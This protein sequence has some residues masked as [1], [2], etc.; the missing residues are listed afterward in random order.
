MSGRLLAV[1][2]PWDEDASFYIFAKDSE[3]RDH[4]KEYMSLQNINVSIS[5]KVT[6]KINGRFENMN[7][8]DFLEKMAKAYDLVWFYDGNIVYIY[9]TDELQTQLIHVRHVKPQEVID[10]AKVLGVGSPQ[11]TIRSVSEEGI[12]LIS[13]PP[14]FVHLVSNLATKLDHSAGTKYADKETIK[15][16]TLEHAWAYDLDFSYR[17]SSITV[18]GVAT[19]LQNIMNGTTGITGS[20]FGGGRFRTAG[21]MATQVDAKTTAMKGLTGQGV[22]GNLRD[23]VEQQMPGNQSKTTQNNSTES[24]MRA[25]SLAGSPPAVIM[26]DMRR[27]AVIVKD[28]KEQ[29]PLYEELIKE[30]D[31]PVKVIAIST[32]IMEIDVNYARTLG[33]QYFNVT[34]GGYFAFSASPSIPSSGSI[35]DVAGT[36]ANLL[37]QGHAKC[38]ESVTSSLIAL[39]T[40]GAGR[41]LSRPTVLTFDNTEAFIQDQTTFYVRVSGTYDANLY[42]ISS[43]L[44]MRVTPHLIKKGDEEKIQLFIDLYDGSTSSSQQE[45]IDG[46]PTTEEIRLTTQAVINKGESLLIGG[47]YLES[48]ST[49]ASGFPILKDLPLLGYLF[50]QE[51][52][53]KT[54]TQRMFLI[55]PSIIEVAAD[56]DTL[57]HDE[58]FMDLAMEANAKLSFLDSKEQREG[59]ENANTSTE[60]SLHDKIVK[61]REKAAEREKERMNL[62]PEAVV[63]ETP[64]HDIINSKVNRSEATTLREKKQVMRQTKS[65]MTEKPKKA[66]EHTSTVKKSTAEARTLRGKKK[67]QRK[68]EPVYK[69]VQPEQ[70]TLKKK[71]P[72]QKVEQKKAEILPSKV[73]FPEKTV[74]HRAQHL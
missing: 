72:I 43:G 18:P 61:R 27:N 28:V 57:L 12:L 15:I 26:A 46:I 56:A 35:T 54:R 22:S 13:G 58:Q 47:L 5:K 71:V 3:L 45:Q 30:L 52:L 64:E 44:S 4:I 69:V 66:I 65:S 59:P 23:Y 1:S 31:V 42:P 73:S 7:P 34:P 50:K 20:S 74:R 32:A 55:T 10:I 16:F 39:E 67:I 17:G 11:F 37:F 2:I 33:L 68:E 19:L 51:K 36:G 62:S 49:L 29:I 8:K 60:S 9:T 24:Q 63:K 21:E 70:K 40:S 6:G 14:K 53:Q 38:F 48:T 41:I 25:S